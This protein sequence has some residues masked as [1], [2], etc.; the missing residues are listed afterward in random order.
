MQLT[1]AAT[2]AAAEKPKPSKTW[3]IDTQKKRISGTIDGLDALRQAV[4]LCLN[5]ER[6]EHVIF[7]FDYGVETKSLEGR[8]FDLIQR[9]LQSAIEDALSVD[10]R[11]SGVGDF[12]FT[13]N[14]DKMTAAFTV[15]SG[16]GSVIMEVDR[17]NV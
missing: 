5:T 9:E 6:Y 7:S 17:N 4:F 1:P 16:N 13:K 10:D 3:T 11:I 15:T 14:K 12:T 8:S 2:A